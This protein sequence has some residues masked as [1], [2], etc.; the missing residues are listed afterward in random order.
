MLFA[1]AVGW[2]P[3]AAIAYCPGNDRLLPHY[4]PKFYSVTEEF[5]RARY[6]VTV[7]VISE[8]W[9]G[10][11]GAKKALKPPFQ[12]GASRP[13]G[14]DPYLGAYYRVK[15]ISVFKGR[16]ST[17][18]RVFSENST[19]RFILN[20][21]ADYL[22]FVTNETFDV[23]GSQFTVDTCGNSA[24]LDKAQVTLSQVRRLARRQQF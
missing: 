24:S 2:M 15:I 3:A 6:V 21:G 22:L 13:W 20:V 8:T 5:S 11:D 1:V 4:D 16:P 9:L 7:R 19:G 12:N 18:L 14:F 17:T 10:E 23:I